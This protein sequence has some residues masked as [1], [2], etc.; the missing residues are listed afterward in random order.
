M[1]NILTWTRL[2]EKTGL[3]KEGFDALSQKVS[4]YYYTSVAAF[5][6]E[7]TAVIQPVLTKLDGGQSDSNIRD[8]TDIHDQLNEI[9]PG[10]AQH[11]ALSQEQ[12]ELKKV[13]KRIAK[14]A[15]EMI[16]S[17][18][19]KEA[20][21]KGLPFEK[22]MVEWAAFDARLEDTAGPRRSS[23]LPADVSKQVSEGA[24]VSA[25]GG[26]SPSPEDSGM[27]V[28]EGAGV[29]NADHTARAVTLSGP[30]EEDT[31]KGVNGQTAHPLS[32]PITSSS[33]TPSANGV[34]MTSEAAATI[35]DSW[36]RG[37]VPWYLNA[38]DISGTTVHEERWTGPETMRAMSETLSEMDEETLMD[39]LEQ[40]NGV[41]E[42][43][44]SAATAASARPR[45]TP[46]ANAA[47]AAAAADAAA[48]EETEE[49]K[50]AREKREK[51]NAKRRAQ[52]RRMK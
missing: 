16:D 12:K 36:A 47:A 15:K 43:E 1:R 51:A 48:E 5:S 27:A 40:S 7:L 37:G 22:E 44:S 24:S 30:T 9:A 2:D 10:T 34:M 52:R 45:R 50:V 14:A 3:F 18:R 39:V 26:A 41:I 6:A 11:L 46:R 49:Q 23:V 21:M 32:P 25:I 19:Q 29:S 13:T 42:E 4:N 28:G 33:I 35:E 20:E 17:A 31:T 8:I 38:F